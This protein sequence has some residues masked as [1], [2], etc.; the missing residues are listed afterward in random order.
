TV[1]MPDPKLMVL[2]ELQ[3]NN[4]LTF[5]PSFQLDPTFFD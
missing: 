1:G 2:D 5:P 4:F 3:N